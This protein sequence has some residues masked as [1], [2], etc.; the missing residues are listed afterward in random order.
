M[1]QRIRKSI[2]LALTLVMM[3]A[4]L[5]GSILPAR[6]DIE[7]G[8]KW[9]LK[10]TSDKSVISAGDTVTITASFNVIAGVF[11]GFEAVRITIFLPTGLEYTS[12]ILYEG[13]IP[14]VLTTSPAATPMGTSIVT[15]ISTMTYAGTA[16]IIIAAKVGSD[17]NG[18]SL[19]VRSGMYLQKTGGDMPN[20]PNEEAVLTLSNG[21]TGPPIPITPVIY[22][23]QFDLAGGIRVGGGA[24]VQAV[25]GGGAAIEPYIYRENYVFQGWDGEFNYV[26][27]DVVVTARWAVKPDT[28]PITINPP[29][30]DLAGSHFKG[31]D[32]FTHLSH[33]PMIYIAEH[34][35][36]YL[37]S[38]E[39][40]DDVLTFGAE[41]VATSGS[42]VDSTAIHIK[43]S[44][45]N[46]LG[47]G[48]YTLRVNFTD[49]TYSNAQLKVIEYKNP[50]TDLTGSDWFF[51]GVE[52]MNAS[53]L[54]QGISSTQFGPNTSMSRG[55]VV[56]LLYRYAGEPGV[57]G[58]TNSFSDIATGQYYTNAVIWAAVNGI[59]LGYEGGTFG[60]NDNI[61]HE[62][63]AAILYR[64]Q[65]ALG[66]KPTDILMDREYSDFDQISLYAK[67]AVNKLTMQGVFRDWP[68]NPGNQ[69]K[70]QEPVTRAEMATVMWRWIESI[71]W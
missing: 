38:V 30:G 29:T 70:P 19:I 69:F 68:S 34:P 57:S 65:N 45:L 26:T 54:L 2:S 63:Y 17:W 53:D 28:G 33:I 39:I 8:F 35:I 1:K 67:S 56:T 20:I 16:K 52:A 12:A 27:H 10:L 66:S 50:F 51:N 64:Y 48:T 49:G 44:Y 58:F 41:Y 11:S 4:L 62:Q 25:A 21:T 43:A 6:A 22:M 23:V 61:T 47:V 15:D 55:M 40:D 42:D 60:P 9:D 5:A 13:D 71:G 14:S 31:K 24:L 32:T 46:S 7:P 18:S 3:A 59:V 36:I 37:H